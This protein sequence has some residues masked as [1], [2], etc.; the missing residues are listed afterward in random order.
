M[1]GSIIRDFTHPD[2]FGE[3]F[4]ARGVVV[5]LERSGPFQ[6]SAMRTELTSVW[7]QRGTA[8]AP[9]VSRAILTDRVHFAFIAEPGHPQF[10]NGRSLQDR[11]FFC[12]FGSDDLFMRHTGSGTWASVS[13]RR[14]DLATLGIATGHGNLARLGASSRVGPLDPVGLRRLRGGHARIERMTRRARDVF[15]SPAV[16]RQCNDQLARALMACLADQ[17]PDA[18]RAATRRHHAIMRR[19]SACLADRPYDPITLTE[20]CE[21]VGTNA[22][23]LNL[24]C[25]EYLDMSPV[26][27]LRL[28]RFRIANRILRQGIPGLDTVTDIA[29]RC[30]FAE[31][32]RF[33]QVYARIFG[34]AP[35]QTLGKS[36]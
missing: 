9:R 14:D 19:V 18:D 3:A 20:L 25:H 1:T 8:S 29:L 5:T 10:W 27:Y 11:E 17:S 35:S 7:L 34:E 36:R 6:G 32:G 21:T 24:C 23:T 31:L 4:R 30:G 2:E 33:A 26:R 28:R 12:Q 15:T 22:R 13:L 16:A